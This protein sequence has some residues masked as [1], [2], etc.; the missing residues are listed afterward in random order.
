MTSVKS[1]AVLAAICATKVS[2][3]T[4]TRASART[5]SVELTDAPIALSQ[6]SIA[7]INVKMV[8][9]LIQSTACA[10]I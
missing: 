9:T 3:S 5:Q 1:Q 7:A 8:T 2:G 6:A 10:S 4:K